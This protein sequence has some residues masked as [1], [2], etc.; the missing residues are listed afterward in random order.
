MSSSPD[1]PPSTRHGEEESLV[2]AMRAAV[3]D[4]TRTLERVCAELG[5]QRR[6]VDVLEPML[7]HLM[8]VVD[9]RIVVVDADRRIVAASRGAIAGGAELGKPLS[10][11]VP[12]TVAER[13]A[14]ELGQDLPGT[15]VEV[16]TG[17]DTVRAHVLPDAGAVVELDP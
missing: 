3:D 17:A 6:R 11:V 5:A 7:D 16:G 1:D 13:L 14:G 2:A 4:A 15:V 10:S 9:V 12:A 8:G